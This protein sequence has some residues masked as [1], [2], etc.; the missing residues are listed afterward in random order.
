M[1]KQIWE[2]LP[3]FTD[4]PVPPLDEE[5][6]A[7]LAKEPAQEDGEYMHNW[8]TADLLYKSEAIGAKYL[9]GVFETKEESAAAFKEWNDKYMDARK[10]LASEMLEEARSSAGTSE[11]ENF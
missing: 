5:M 3:D 4:E 8:G 9:L 2:T 6:L 1:G 11:Q 10:D 7:E